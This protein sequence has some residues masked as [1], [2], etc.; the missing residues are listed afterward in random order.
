VHAPIVEALAL[1]K[2]YKAD[3]PSRVKC[4]A[5]G[6][7]VPVEGIIPAELAELM[8]RADSKRRQRILRTVYECGVFQALREKLR[9][10]EIWVAGAEKWR[11][12]DLDLPAD[13]EDRRAENYA[14]LRKPLDPRRFTGEMREELDAELSA[15]NDAL[16]GQGPGLAEDRR[17][18]Q[19]RGDP[20]HAA[21]RRARAAEPAPAEDGDP[22]PVGRGAADGHAHRNL[23]AHRLPER[24]HPG[25]HPEPPGPAGAV[26][27][28]PAADLRLRHRHRDPRGGRRRSPAH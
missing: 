19:R 23:P 7:H 15:L 11:N 3:V 17:A 8:Y 20:P 9:C 6:E 22:G 2:R 24:L 16:G 10:K 25:R 1:I 26:R 21:G 13:F 27:A 14:Q 18:A 5:P 28:A 4:Y 12:P